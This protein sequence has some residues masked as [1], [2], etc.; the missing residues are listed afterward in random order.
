MAR[1]L[2]VEYE[3]AIYHVTIRG[4]ERRVIFE[5]DADRIRFIERLGERVKDFGVRLYLFVLMKN[6]VHMVFETPEGNLSRFMHSLQTAYSVYFNLKHRRSGHLLQGRFGAKVVEGDEYLLKLSRYVHLNPVFVAKIRGLPVK[7]RIEYLRRYEWSTYRGYISSGR[8][9]D[10][11]EYGPMLA[12]MEV[13]RSKQRKAYRKYVEAGIAETDREWK[14]AMK[15]SRLGIGG[16]LFRRQIWDKH[17]DLLEGRGKKEDVSLRKTSRRVEVGK[18]LEAVA[19]EYGVDAGRIR[20]RQRGTWLRPV[21]AKMLCRYGGL[22]QRDAAAI[23]NLKTGVAVSAQIRS[24][25][26]ERSENRLLRRHLDR[27]EQALISH[28]D[29]KYQTKG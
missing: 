13:K 18:I 2:R 19:A 20:E 5:D 24:L 10:F 12:L 21:A 14:D 6:H 29:A 8:R 7:N 23:M 25:E 15:E 1:L 3:G 22:T 17:T 28:N 9:L 16:E 11:V 26:T 4:N 27:I